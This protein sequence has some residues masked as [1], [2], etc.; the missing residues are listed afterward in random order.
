MTLKWRFS[1]GI[2]FS[3]L[4]HFFLLSALLYWYPGMIGRSDQ[5]WQEWSQFLAEKYCP[6]VQ[7]AKQLRRLQQK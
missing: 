6:L 7:S 2:L 1:G 3:L 4:L 5:P